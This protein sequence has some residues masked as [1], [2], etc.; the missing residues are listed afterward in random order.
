MN[1]KSIYPC[2]WFNHNAQEAADLYCSAFKDSKITAANPIVVTFNL[3]GQQ[4]MALNGGPQLTPNPSISFYTVCASREEVKN[5][6][7]IFLDGGKVLMPLDAY[8][9]SEYYGWIQ[10]KFGATWQLALGKLEDVGQQYSPMLMFTGKNAG[11]AEE[12]IKMY[13]SIF[14]PGSIQGIM[15]Y[16]PGEGDVEGTIKHAQFTLGHYVMMAMDSSLPHAF[17]FTDGI[18]LVALCD[19]QAQIDYFWNRLTDGGEESMCGWL[20]DR[21]GVS[22]QIIPSVLEKMMGHPQKS[23]A[24]V[25]AFLKMRKFDI[26]TLEKAYE[27]G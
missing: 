20:K 2:L 5:A 13:T 17:T 1:H 12:A 8:P 3:N 26:A 7:D 4:F 11:K 25:Q 22:W 16:A 21:Y 27:Q 14:E 9:W 6:W 23:Q 24:V 15:R 18:S 19:N 10:D